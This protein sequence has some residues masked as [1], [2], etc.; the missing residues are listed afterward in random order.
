MCIH[1]SLPK[2]EDNNV[3]TE[4]NGDSK[5]KNILG[6]FMT[7]TAKEIKTGAENAAKGI[8]PG[9]KKGISKDEQNSNN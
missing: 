6:Q 1:I 5:S 8:R 9:R 4:E 7:N 2:Y 3:S